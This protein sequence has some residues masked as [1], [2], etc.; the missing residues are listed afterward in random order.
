MSGSKW[1]KDLI[2]EYVICML[3]YTYYSPFKWAFGP[4][5]T[6]G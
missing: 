1:E 6:S 5:K 4:T 3:E 2:N